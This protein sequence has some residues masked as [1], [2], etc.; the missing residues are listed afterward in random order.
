M[1]AS[2]G[3]VTVADKASLQKILEQKH[4]IDVQILHQEK[5]FQDLF[6]QM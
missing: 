4:A 6:W 5:S 3:R 2:M 1:G